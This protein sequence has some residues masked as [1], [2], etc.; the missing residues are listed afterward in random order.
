MTAP[1]AAIFRCEGEYW[2]AG[3]SENSFRLRDSKGL[4]HL[5]HLLRH[6]GTDFHVLDLV[7]G[8]TGSADE[9]AAIPSDTDQFGATAVRIGSLGDAGEML[10]DRARTEYQRRLSEL[11][12]ELE[13]AGQLHNEARME[14]AEREM[15]ALTAELSR[16]VGLR[17]R[18]RRAGSAAERARQSV[19]KTIKTAIDRAAE[20]DPGFA[21]VLSKCIRTG[22]TCS[23]EPELAFPIKWEFERSTAEPTSSERASSAD[24]TN[25]LTMEESVS[26]E[27]THSSAIFV[28]R[29]RELTDLRGAL[30]DVMRGQGRL[31]LL[32]GE[33]GIGKTRLANELARLAATQNVQV[34]WGRCWEG[35]GAPAYWPIRQIIRACL[36][37]HNPGQQEVLLGSGAREI[38]QLIPEIRHSRPLPEETGTTSDPDA[39]RFRLFGSVA[40]FMRN[41]ARIATLLIVIDDLHD[42]DQPSLEML[43]F[44]ACETKDAPIMILGTYRDSEVRRSRELGKLV[45]DL[46]REGWTLPIAGL[47]QVEVRQFV[48]QSSGQKAK[49]KLVADLYHATNGNPLF[50]EGVVRLLIAEGKIDNEATG[51][52]IPDGVRESIRRR[53]A[54]LS[55]ETVLMLSI[56][57]VIGNE[58][59]IRLLE[60]TS[61]NPAQLVV[62][63]L[64][65]ARRIGIVTADDYPPIRRYRFSHALVREALYQEMAAGRRIELHGQIGAAI[66]KICENDLK[67]HQAALAHHFTAARSTEKAIEYSIGAGE[68][69][70]AVFAYQEA[71]SHWETALQLMQGES[72]RPRRRAREIELASMLAQALFATRGNTAPETREAAARARD[73]AEKT[74]NLSQIVRQ[75]FLIYRAAIVSG[76]YSSAAALA[77]QILDFAGREGSPT[78]LA[79][80][81][82]AQLVWRLFRGDLVG[83]EEHFARWSAFREAAGYG[84]VPGEVVVVL[85]YASLCAGCLGYAEKARERIAEAIALARVTKSP[86]DLAMGRLFESWLYRL[87]REPRASD[88]AATQAIALSE[89]HGFSIAKPRARTY[90]GW[91]RAQ[92]GSAGEGVSMIRQG[93]AGAKQIGA[94]VSITDG[95]TCLAEAQ[96]LDDKIADAVST[97]EEALQANPEEL[98]YRPNILTCRGELRIK[99]GQAE[100]AEADFREAIA[101]AQKMSARGWELRSTNSLARLMR[102]TGRR[103]EA[104]KMLAE[105]YGWFTEG[106]DTADL[107]DAKA[108]LDELSD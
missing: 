18:I 70:W 79:F 96:A 44:V 89:E 69:A 77:D 68:A 59:D 76:D 22:M 33:P 106:F 95:L 45:G 25:N 86:F 82:N 60:S 17:G 62:E 24:A 87:L 3:F 102:D 27:L 83:A 107:K 12:E 29:R 99:L 21:A 19:T 103:D 97:I 92:L 40:S 4:T 5:A 48:E 23:Y 90:M 91:A 10:D 6:P 61:G 100:L 78:S 108:Q 105:I 80:A 63:Q 20:Q 9:T 58:F 30:N 73:L 71:R 81:H 2:T 104:R 74:G 1:R 66:E 57:S 26:S 36:E 8:M 51:F 43:R 67:P 35:G 85:S 53:L 101:L 28:G 52:E 42:A 11:R 65:D 54:V 98:V 93:L 13:E 16:A 41:A 64:E 88:A 38:A 37:K 56:A 72:D 32:G 34:F 94:R 15:E 7:G 31:F 47:S 39:A 55:A 50:V 49:E 75:L 84:Q 46:I 14:R